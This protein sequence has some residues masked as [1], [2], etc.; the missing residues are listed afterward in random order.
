MVLLLAGMAAMVVVCAGAAFATSV[1]EVEPNDSIAQAQSIDASFSLDSDPNITDSTTVPHATV[2]ATGNGTLD[3][4]AFT[5]PDAGVGTTG[6]FDVDGACCISTG[7]FDSYMRLYDSTGNFLAENVDSPNDPGS[8]PL[9]DGCVIN[10]DSYITHNFSSAGTYYLQVSSCCPFPARP[11]PNAVSYKLNVSVHDHPYTNTADTTPPD[12]SVSHTPDGTNGWNKT[13]PVTLN[14]S[15]GDSGSGLAADPTCKD[16]DNA[17]SLTAGT[18]AG[19]WTASISGE[20]IHTIEC[21]VDD[22]AGNSATI[23]D[24]V[25]I[26]TTAPK[27]KS[28]SPA[29]NATRVSRTANVTATFSEAMN[30]ASVEAPGIVTLK[31]SSGGAA[32]AATVTY[33]PTTNKVILNPN[34]SLARNTLLSAKVTTG[35]T[36]LAGNQLDQNSTTGGNQAKSWTFTT[37]R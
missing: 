23:G 31:K 30:E 36:D 1:N 24:Q 14:V 21:T 4:Y 20:G 34:V 13:S 5:V 10:G 7:G 6:V 12:L 25:K 32:V 11:V 19:T 22:R 3:Y 37:V 18:T 27:V 2:D 8:P 35:A 9:C 33:N 28:T 17:L 16:G 15:A 29:N 26:D